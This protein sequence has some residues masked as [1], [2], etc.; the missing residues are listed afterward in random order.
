MI[1]LIVGQG[2]GGQIFRGADRGPHNQ[3]RPDLQTVSSKIGCKNCSNLSEDRRR[4][5]LYFGVIFAG[6]LEGDQIKQR[7]V[8]KVSCNI[9]LLVYFEITRRPQNL[10]TR[11]A[12]GPRNGL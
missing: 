3:R 11:A 7:K 6:I 8:D 12:C 9:S 10:L 1:T 2:R 5:L 4:F